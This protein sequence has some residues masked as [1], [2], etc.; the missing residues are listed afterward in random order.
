MYHLQCHRI[1]ALAFVLQLPK[2][3]LLTVHVYACA[4]LCGSP[5]RHHK[6][7]GWVQPSHVDAGGHWWCYGYTDTRKQQR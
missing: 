5:L 4:V 2:A 3:C 6:V 7:A 1:L